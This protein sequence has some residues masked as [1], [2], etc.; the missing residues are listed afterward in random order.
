MPSHYWSERELKREVPPGAQGSSNVKSWLQDLCQENT[1]GDREKTRMA[2]CV[3]LA[4]NPSTLGG[5]GGRITRSGAPDQPAQGN[6]TLFLLKNPKIISWM[7]WCISVVS[8]TQSLRWE[9]HVSLG[10]QGCSELWSCHCTATWVKEWDP[11]SGKK[12]K[13]QR[14]RRKY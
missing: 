14:E 8:A 1:V 7:C 5:P 2:G 10:G 11:I 12:K 6:E 4:C 13:R 9:N 3:A